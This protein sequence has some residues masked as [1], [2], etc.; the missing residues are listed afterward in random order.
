MTVIYSGTV[1]EAR[2]PESG[3]RQLAPSGDSDEPIPGMSPGS[4]GHRPFWVLPV[5]DAAFSIFTW[6]T[7]VSTCS[8][9]SL[10]RTL[11]RVRAHPNPM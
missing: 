3:H 2:S 8:L 4:W 10:V 7:L 11:V 1:L 5:V 9:L 6:L